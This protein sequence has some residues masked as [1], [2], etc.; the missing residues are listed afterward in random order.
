MM[1]ELLNANSSTKPHHVYLEYITIYYT[2]LLSFFSN[3]NPVFP[4]LLQ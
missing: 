4:G 1:C 3:Q 2:A